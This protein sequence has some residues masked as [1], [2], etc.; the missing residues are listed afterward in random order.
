MIRDLNITCNVLIPKIE[1]L[2]SLREFRPISLYNVVYKIVTKYLATKF[3]CIMPSLISPNQCSFVL[4]RSN[5][6]NS[7]MAQKITHS[8][9]K[10]KEN[11][12]FMA[13]KIDLEKVYGMRKRERGHDRIGWSFVVDTLHDTGV[14]NKII[15]LIF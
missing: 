12:G 11:R 13:I 9:R 4:S 10:M 5:T 3:Q 7:I 15:S 8:M 6:D 1:N 14:D 2:E